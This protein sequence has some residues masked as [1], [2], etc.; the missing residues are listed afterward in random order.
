MEYLSI[1]FVMSFEHM[2]SN[3]YIFFSAKL[4]HYLKLKSNKY[5]EFII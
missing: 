2:P 4:N 3:E 5:I 1:N